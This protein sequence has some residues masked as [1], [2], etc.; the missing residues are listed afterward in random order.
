MF[1]HPYEGD[2]HN[3]STFAYCY[4]RM[5]DFIP[6]LIAQGCN[7]RV[8]LDYSGTLL[9]GLQQMGRQDILDKLRRITCDPTYQPYVEWLGT[10]WGHA[11][12]S[13]TPVPDLKLHIRAWQHHFAAPVRDRSPGQSARVFAP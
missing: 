13:S 1:E 12:V 2:N 9:W 3:A 5:G 6:E 7:P 10:L 11:V 8:M 4:A